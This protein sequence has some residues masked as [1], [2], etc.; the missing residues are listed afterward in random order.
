M[1]NQKMNQIAVVNSNTSIYS[2]DVEFDRAQRMAKALSSSD[3]V[4]TQYRN[5]IANTLIALEMANRTGSSPIMVM[6]NLSIIQG[7]PSWSSSFIIAALNSCG[8]FTPLRFKVTDLGQKTVSYD[9]WV[10][11]QG[12]RQK[13][14]KQVVIHDKS[15]VA[16]AYD[17]NGELVEGPPVSVSMAVHEGWYTKSDSKWVTMTDLMLNYRA[18]A[19]F[20]RLYAPDIL[21]GMH[22]SDEITDIS[23]G[24]ATP[25]SAPLAVQ[26]LNEKV[27]PNTAAQVEDVVDDEDIL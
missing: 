1:E 15:C 23:G 10:G 4:P 18:A 17:K 19:F 14:T 27:N 21:Q 13:Q 26:I 6:Q 7:K 3:M 24:A 9:F 22:T 20:G 8:R 12:Q 16:Y 2:N 25:S 11:P 5:N